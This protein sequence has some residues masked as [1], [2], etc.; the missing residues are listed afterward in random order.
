M[1]REG[2]EGM[3]EEGRRGEERVGRGELAAFYFVHTSARYH[4]IVK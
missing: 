2:G 4:A 3:S 1:R